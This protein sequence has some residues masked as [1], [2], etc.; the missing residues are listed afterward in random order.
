[1]SKIDVRQIIPIIEVDDKEVSVG[2]LPALG[3]DSHW[4]FSN[5]V[6]LHYGRVKVTVQ[7]R[8]LI[9]AINNAMNTG[10]H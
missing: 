6:V 9:T 4:S 2:T 10:E 5:W 8:A 7:G 1:M 3:V